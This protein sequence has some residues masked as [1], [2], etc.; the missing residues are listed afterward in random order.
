[1]ILH[2]NETKSRAFFFSFFSSLIILDDSS[3]RTSSVQEKFVRVHMDLFG[4]LIVRSAH[5]KKYM[6]VMTY[7]FSMYTELAA[8]C[9]K[10]VDTVA[11]AFFEQWIC[12]HGVLAII[13]SDR[14]KNSF[15]TL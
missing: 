14:W 8:I 11:R 1:M 2:S 9:D 12:R 15:M 10:K 13:V 3:L 5:G 6:M 7:A 4:P